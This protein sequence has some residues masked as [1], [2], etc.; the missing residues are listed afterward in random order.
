MAR[1]ARIIPRFMTAV[2]WDWG[3]GGEP[4]FT[5]ASLEK[6]TCSLKPTV[7]LDLS[8]KTMGDRK[9]ENCQLARGLGHNGS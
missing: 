9:R 4:L 1:E 2:D 7:N 3:W 8:Y 6:K 5:Q